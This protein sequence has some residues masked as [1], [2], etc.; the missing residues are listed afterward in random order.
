MVCSRSR[1]ISTSF[2]SRHFLPA[3]GALTLAC[4][5]SLQ[6]QAEL[7]EMQKRYGGEERDHLVT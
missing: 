6:W 3:E 7:D 5:D 1:C 4:A 2:L